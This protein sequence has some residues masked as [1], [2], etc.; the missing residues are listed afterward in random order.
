MKGG[1]DGGTDP[2]GVG[3]AGGWEKPLC[4]SRGTMTVAVRNTSRNTSRLYEK[5]AGHAIVGDFGELRFMGLVLKLKL[6]GQAMDTVLGLKLTV[7]GQAMGTVL[8]LK[9]KLTGQ[10]MNTVLGS[11]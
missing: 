9:L 3:E 8:G 10:A 11:S 1:L 7:T 4:G 5:G 6:T 2:E